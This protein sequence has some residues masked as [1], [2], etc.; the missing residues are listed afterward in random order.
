MKKIIALALSLCCISLVTAKAKNNDEIGVIIKPGQTETGRNV[1]VTGV[2]KM[3]GNM[4]FSYPGIE[5]SS[6]KKYSLVSGDPKLLKKVRE[7]AGKE[8]IITG[9]V[10]RPVE[11]DVKPFQMLKDGYLY[12]ESYE[13]V[14]TSKKKK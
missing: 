4:P 7:C 10:N 12:I 1:S 6:G 13:V 2:V 3:Y 9:V 14:K 8:V 11:D 5:T